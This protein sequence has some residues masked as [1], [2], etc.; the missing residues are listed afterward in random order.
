MYRIHMKQSNFFFHQYI[1]IVTYTSRET[2][3]KDAKTSTPF[4]VKKKN[5]HHC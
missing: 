3:K 5:I 2:L 4:N 1:G